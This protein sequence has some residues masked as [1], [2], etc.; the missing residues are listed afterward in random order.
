M[1]KKFIVNSDQFEQQHPFLCSFIFLAAIAS[2]SFF[3]VTLK[4]AI[5]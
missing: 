3:I 2:A 4:F 1:I 5:A